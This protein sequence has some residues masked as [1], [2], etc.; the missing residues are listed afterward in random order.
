MAYVRCDV[1][2]DLYPV[3]MIS[4]PTDSNLL[5]GQPAVE[6]DGAEVE[7]QPQGFHL[8][9]SGLA[10][11]VDP[12]LRIGR[13]PSWSSLGGE[14]EDHD[15]VSAR[16]ATVWVDD[17]RLMVRDEGSTNGTFIDGRPCEPHQPY[18]A[19]AG[20]RLQLSSALVL[21]VEVGSVPA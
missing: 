14:L 5:V 7:Q 11:E 17:G 20:S 15:V 2:G 6:G 10:V 3:G 18:E 4:C 8:L 19:P 12:E 9:G 16:H 1:C 13:D 21:T